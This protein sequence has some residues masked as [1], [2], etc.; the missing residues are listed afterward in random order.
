LPQRIAV[1]F[2]A[3][4]APTKRPLRLDPDSVGAKMTKKRGVCPRN[5]LKKERRT[6]IQHFTPVSPFLCPNN[7]AAM[8]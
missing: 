1:L 6:E 3:E 5:S 8:R 4:N 2:C 7:S